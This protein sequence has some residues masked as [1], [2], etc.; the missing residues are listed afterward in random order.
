MSVPWR[1]RP[2]D[3]TGCAISPAATAEVAHATLSLSQPK[4]PTFTA[5][6]GQSANAPESA[7]SFIGRRTRL[8][9]SR[10]RAQGAP[11]CFARAC[12]RLAALTA[13]PANLRAQ[14][15]TASRGPLDDGRQR[16]Y[17]RILFDGCNS[18]P[19]PHRPM[20]SIRSAAPGHGFV[21]VSGF[22]PWSATRTT[23]CPRIAR[24]DR[25][26]F[27]PQARAPDPCTL[28]IDI[29]TLSRLHACQASIRQEPHSV[30]PIH[31]RTRT[32][33]RHRRSTWAGVSWPNDDDIGAG[34]G[35]NIG[36]T[37]ARARTAKSTRDV[38]TICAPSS[39]Y[40]RVRRRASF[41]RRD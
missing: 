10:S 37:L 39:E 8:C 16:R 24:S 12:A 31:S 26:A 36:R 34:G 3:L 6:I 17:S 18:Q 23:T 35:E 4:Q 25:T 27:R 13:R 33:N 30:L 1:E 19:P 21:F 40:L 22:T 5:A 38:T 32:R 28:Q 20:W 14:L 11:R 2:R 7:S 9:G 29:V 41:S 15:P